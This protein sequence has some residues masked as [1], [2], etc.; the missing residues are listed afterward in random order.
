MQHL[1]G[2][3]RLQLS[4]KLAKSLFQ[5][6]YKNLTYTL[7]DPV[8]TEITTRLRT[9]L[10]DALERALQNKHNIQEIQS[11]WIDMLEDIKLNYVKS[12]AEVEGEQLLEKA[13]QLHKQVL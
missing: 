8:G 1:P 3:R 4:K 11:L 9:N 2:L 6:T 10:K 5:I 13:E 7:K 12:I